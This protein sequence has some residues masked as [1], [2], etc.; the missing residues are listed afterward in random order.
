MVNQ[1]LGLSILFFI[2]SLIS[3]KPGGPTDYYN[4]INCDS[5]NFGNYYKLGQYGIEAPFSKEPV[6]SM[7]NENDKVFN[8]QYRSLFI[9][10]KDTLILGVGIYKIKD[11]LVK[12]DS[13][14][15]LD[16]MRNSQRFLVEK[17]YRGHLINSDTGY[18]QGRYCINDKYNINI[19]FLGVEHKQNYYTKSFNYNNLIVNLFAITPRNDSCKIIVDGFFKKIKTN[20]I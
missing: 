14:K 17:Q 4:T 2:I 19:L 12:I 10:R 7:D 15:L 9:Y 11:K 18:F 1:Y 8:V 20:C 3:C 13:L 5:I 6:K 16:L